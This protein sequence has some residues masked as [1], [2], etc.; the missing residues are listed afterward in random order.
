MGGTA[1]SVALQHVN[2]TPPPLV[3][4]RPDVPPHLAAIVNRM[5]EKKPVNRFQSFHEVLQA[6]QAAGLTSDKPLLLPRSSASRP[7]ARNMLQRALDQHRTR[8]GSILP[9]FLFLAV[10]VPLL[11]W[12]SGFVYRT[13]INPP[14]LGQH[15]QEIPKKPTVEE[16]WVYAS[17][18]RTP[19]AWQA[20]ADYFPQEAYY[21][22]YKAKRQLIRYHYINEE[23][24]KSLPLFQEFADLGSFYP[25]EQ[26]LGYAGLAWCYAEGSP[27]VAQDYL[28]HIG[29]NTMF[30]TD[31]LFRQILDATT[32]ALRQK[33]VEVPVGE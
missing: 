31:E 32:K 15:T 21:W 10:L 9:L 28:S 22:G 30:N 17:F 19:E 5:I 14:F 1:L 29:L 4:Q 25:E 18:V 11:G 33:K 6:L 26:M 12:N 7:V 24:E 2:N 23:K 16:Q 3:K 8:I 27:Q 13:W 20:V